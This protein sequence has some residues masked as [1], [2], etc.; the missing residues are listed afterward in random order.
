MCKQGIKIAVFVWILWLSGC[1]TGLYTSKHSTAP[2]FGPVVKGMT[3]A[4]AEDHLGR[5]FLISGISENQYRALYEY[6]LGMSPK[7][8]IRMDVMDF[9]TAGM[10]VL[11]VNPVDRF[12]GS[13]HLMA[14]VYRMEDGYEKNDRVVEVHEKIRLR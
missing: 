9:V 8:M 6:R 11:I 7:E 10:G 2:A 14:V 1:S 3:R 5:P 13:E 4:E 12:T